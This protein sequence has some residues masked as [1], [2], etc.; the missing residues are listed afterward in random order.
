MTRRSLDRT[1]N[2]SLVVSGLVTAVTGAVLLT[3]F[4]M[5]FGPFATVAFGVDRLIWLDLHRLAA[6]AMATG[7][8][9]HVVLHRNAFS[10]HFASLA[11]NDG[12]HP[13]DIERLLYLVFFAAGATGFAAWLLV[14]DATP[15]LG[16]VVA[17][18]L[19]G[20]RH[21]LADAHNIAALATLGLAIH[22]VRHRWP[23]LLGRRPTPPVSRRGGPADRRTV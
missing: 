14:E 1:I 10:S 19:V 8:A 5:G 9:L 23:A 22:H 17:L 7:I 6:L 3:R 2:W 15:L 11:G 4:H 18:P 21:R 20:G 13:I 16:P 12:G